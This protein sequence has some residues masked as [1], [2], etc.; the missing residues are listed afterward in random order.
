MNA[1]QVAN[2]SLRLLLLGLLLCGCG[3]KPVGHSSPP[4]PPTAEQTQRTRLH[5]VKVSEKDR[6]LL[7][8]LE[9]LSPGDSYERVVSVL[10]EPAK[11]APLRSK[12]FHTSNKGF[13]ATY[14][15]GDFAQFEPYLCLVFNSR[16]ALVW[17]DTNVD[18]IPR[19]NTPIVLV[20]W[21]SDEPIREFLVKQGRSRELRPGESYD[22]AVKEK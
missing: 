4:E 11:K 5:A 21:E 8:K 17:I 3:Q 1:V 16:N 13:A 22:E 7:E 9:R 15:D 10:G 12:G 6:L 19:L 14:L 20:V 18:S 2:G